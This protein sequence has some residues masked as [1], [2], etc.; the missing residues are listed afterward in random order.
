MQRENLRYIT[1]LYHY[2]TIYPYQ[3]QK[4]LIIC[5]W[6]AIWIKYC[7]KDHLV[8]FCAWKITEWHWRYSE[9]IPSQYTFTLYNHVIISISNHL[10]LSRAWQRC[11]IKGNC[12]TFEEGHRENIY[13]KYDPISIC[14]DHKGLSKSLDP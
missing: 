11:Y 10:V 14:S 9:I 6:A 1:H 13:T 3:F 7:I 5:S 12:A 2:I 8:T 4:V